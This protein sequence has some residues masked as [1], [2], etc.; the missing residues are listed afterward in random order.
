M[1]AQH[2]ISLA[3]ARR[4]DGTRR[5]ESERDRTMTRHDKVMPSA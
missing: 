1:V 2:T 4:G 3:R 5:D